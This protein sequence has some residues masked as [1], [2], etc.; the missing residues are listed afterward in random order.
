MKKRVCEVGE[1]NLFSMLVALTECKSWEGPVITN[2]LR[3]L[4]VSS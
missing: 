3:L 4:S 2:A 1:A